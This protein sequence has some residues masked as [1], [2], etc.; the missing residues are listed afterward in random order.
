MRFHKTQIMQILIQREHKK[1]R[2]LLYIFLK[3]AE[4][5]TDKKEGH[6]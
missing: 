3:L 4:I 1:K 6:L 2:S 5:L